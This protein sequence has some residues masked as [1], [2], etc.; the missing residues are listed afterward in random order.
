MCEGQLK[1]NSFKSFVYQNPEY[2]MFKA[3][4]IEI[5][6]KML[7]DYEGEKKKSSEKLF[8]LQGSK[9]KIIKASKYEIL[10]N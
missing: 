5:V 4:T 7:T 8:N 6:Q 3:T 9:I 10:F 2:R 1:K